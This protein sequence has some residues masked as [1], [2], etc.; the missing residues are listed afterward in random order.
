MLK[1][2]TR[3]TLAVLGLM[4][5]CPVSANDWY[6]D[7]ATGSDSNGGSSW[8]DAWRTVSHA[9]A[10]APLQAGE[11]IQIAAGLYDTAHGE[12]FPI[13]ARP[14]RTFIGVDGS[15]S[16]ILDA[17]STGLSVLR[18]NGWNSYLNL[19]GLTLRE[20]TFGIHN[21]VPDFESYSLD[22]VD[23]QIEAT[24]TAIFCSL[25]E[26]V[27]S[28]TMDSSVLHHNQNGINI[29]SI[30]HHANLNFHA[31]D[32]SFSDNLDYG[33]R[34]KIAGPASSSDTSWR[35]CQFL[36]NGGTGLVLVGGAYWS[37]GVHAK[38][39]DCLLA[40]NRGSGVVNDWGRTRLEGCTVADN[41]VTGNLVAVDASCLMLG[42]LLF[43]NGDDLLPQGETSASYC[44]IGDGDLAGTNNNFSADPL[45][46]DPLVEDYR[47]RFGSPC[48]DAGEPDLVVP[49]SDLVG[50]PRDLDGDLVGTAAVDVGAL[51]LAPLEL[52]G[53]PSIGSIVELQLWGPPSGISRVFIHRGP[54]LNPGVIT[55]FGELFLDR[56]LLTTI[57]SGLT[58][59]GPPG[60]LP[61][62]IPPASVLVGRTVTLQA[63]SSNGSP[64]QP[65]SLTNPIEIVFLP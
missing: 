9:A 55:P 13:T 31:V 60:S 33:V 17:G 24:Q 44:D 45:F 56:A 52:V 2:F 15:G 42:S 16:T 58:Q 22:L 57:G 34:L 36:R 27:M 26:G 10:A 28:V 6:V 37:V 29:S 48:V 35:R 18:I 3:F 47:L 39:Y 50:T 63:I 46:V 43:G 51:E 64:L 21:Y 30:G 8:A 4:F 7:A 14:G 25:L 12:S 62:S 23:V 11:V 61:W 19:S 53:T 32:S 65:W 49:R 38:L 5:A 41:A 40:K 20:A 1:I 59:L 54:A